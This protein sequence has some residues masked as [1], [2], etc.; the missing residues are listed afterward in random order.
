MENICCTKTYKNFNVE[1]QIC[2]VCNM[3]SVEDEVH[4]L[5]HC[6]M[7]KEQRKLLFIK[8]TNVYK[9]FLNMSNEE[10][11]SLIINNFEKPSN[12]YLYYSWYILRKLPVNKELNKT[13]K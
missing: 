8:I 12:V 11:L 7:Y 4:F 6:P 13:R 1:E 3:S 5:C 2:L 10:Q 9:Y